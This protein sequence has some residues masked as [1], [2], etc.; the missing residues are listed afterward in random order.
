MPAAGL[1]EVIDY[2]NTRRKRFTTASHKF[3]VVTWIDIDMT[4]FLTVMLLLY[5]ALRLSYSC[6]ERVSLLEFHFFAVQRDHVVY[7]AGSV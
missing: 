3:Q 5:L 1:N 2:H 6:G 4:A 7:R